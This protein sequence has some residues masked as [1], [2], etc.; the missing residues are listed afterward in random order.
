MGKT[1]YFTSFYIL[2]IYLMVCLC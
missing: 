1:N 2:N